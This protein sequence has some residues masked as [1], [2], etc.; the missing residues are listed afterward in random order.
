MTTP[1]SFQVKANQLKRL[2][3]PKGVLFDL[4]GTLVESTLDFNFLRQHFNLRKGEDILAVLAAMPE[5]ERERAEQMIQKQ[6]LEDAQAS[7]SL[8]GVINLLTS[9]RAAGIPVAVITRNSRAAAQLKVDN[10]NLA[11]DLLLTREDAKPKPAPQALLQV[12]D[13]WQF[14]VGDCWYIG[15]Y[16]YDLQAANNAGML[17]CLY[18]GSH[19][20][21]NVS[22][23]F[24][25]LAEVVVEHF[26]DLNRAWFDFC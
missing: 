16:L 21:I 22:N 14:N 17:A 9:L 23:S 8:P 20:D 6:E 10:N 11:I 2:P 25:H 26:D 3:V 24:I 5:H 15:D 7:A 12:A 13:Q 4:D 19:A 18:T 1:V